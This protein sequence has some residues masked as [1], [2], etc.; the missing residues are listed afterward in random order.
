MKRVNNKRG[1]KMSKV[2]RFFTISLSILV[3]MLIGYGL[4]LRDNGLI[5]LTVIASI[6]GGFIYLAFDSKEEAQNE[7][8]H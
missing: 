8:T 1:H 4:G 5:I 6:G 7:S 3:L 2:S